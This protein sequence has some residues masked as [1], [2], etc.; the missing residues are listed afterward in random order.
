MLHTKK[1]M[2]LT[3][4]SKIEDFLDKIIIK[5]IRNWIDVLLKGDLHSYEKELSSSLMEVHNFISEQ[6]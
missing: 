5:P 3:T 2:N 4:E 6:L 1:T